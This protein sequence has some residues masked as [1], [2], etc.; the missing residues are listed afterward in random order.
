MQL[1]PKRF[2]DDKDPCFDSI[3]HL[4]WFYTLEKRREKLP[5]LKQALV[6]LENDGLNQVQ[7]AEVMGIDERELRDYQDFVHGVSRLA[8]MNDKNAA[9]VQT[10]ID[11]SYDSYRFLDGKIAFSKTIYNISKTFGVDGRIV[12]ELWDC[13]PT[14]YPADYKGTK[15]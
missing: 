12:V 14:L 1:P 5:I 6:L 13:D 2:N 8:I 3:R 10:I 11:E 7:V 15:P 9:R 4:P